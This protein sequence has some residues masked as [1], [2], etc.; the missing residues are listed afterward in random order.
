MHGMRIGVVGQTASGERRVA[1]TP[2]VAAQ[3][4]RGGHQVA[5]E[6]G[7]GTSAGYDDNAYQKAGCGIGS[8]A[9]TA[10]L[11]CTIDLPERALPEGAAVVGL[12][13]PF[14]EPTAMWRLARQGVTAFAFEAVPRTT[15]AQL[16]DVLSSQ[17]TVSGYQAVLEAASASDRLFP[18]LT[19][20][21]GTVRPASVLVLGAGVAGLQ[22]VATARRLG[23][24][25]SAFDVRAA[26][27]EQV[28]SLGARFVSLEVEPQDA[29]TS[30]GYA[31]QLGAEAEQRLL[32]GLT[33]HVAA[34]DVVIA[35]AAIPGRPAPRL[36]T[37]KAVEGMRLG[38][39]IVDV[40]ATTGGNCELTEP[41]KVVTHHGVHIVGFTDLPSRKP[42]HASQMYARNLA[43]LVGTL[44]SAE[45][46]LT[47]DLEDEIVDG[48]CVVLAGEVR[49]PAIKEL[50]GNTE[51]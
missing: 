20:A 50:P 5:V 1:L 45:G 51:V 16:V 32:V 6:P 13:R 14:D 43:A 41:G 40:A 44:S 10:D 49:H 23:A 2:D 29:A 18:M 26:A 28:A 27:A 48:C 36:I 8:D 9:W 12:L 39:V 33:P 31:R 42:G 37:R 7:A 15:R 35:T 22:A 34:A 46:E 4:I 47:I 25:V 19:T 24:V 17:A 21:A 3:L 38:A 30:G 11:I